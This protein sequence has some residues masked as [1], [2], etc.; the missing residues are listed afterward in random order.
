MLTIIKVLFILL[1]VMQSPVKYQLLTFINFVQAFEQYT[2]KHKTVCSETFYGL[3]SQQTMLPLTIYD[4]FITLV[5]LVI[6]IFPIV[7]KMFLHGTPTLTLKI[8][9]R[10]FSY[11][12]KSF[13]H[14]KNSKR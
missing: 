4:H 11:D 7:W 8:V 12:P 9:L 10:D 1:E 2:F 3:V 5:N 6:T 13:S 14:L